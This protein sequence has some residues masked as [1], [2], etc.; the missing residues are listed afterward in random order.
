[1]LLLIN[2]CDCGWQKGLFKKVRKL[3]YRKRESYTFCRMLCAYLK[4]FKKPASVFRLQGEHASYAGEVVAICGRRR[5]PPQAQ[6]SALRGRWWRH[7]RATIGQDL[8]ALLAVVPQRY[9]LRLSPVCVHAPRVLMVL[10]P[11]DSRQLFKEFYLKK[12]TFQRRLCQKTCL[13]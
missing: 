13:N 1:M 11:R 3:T 5:A 9:E 6:P 8:Q 7:A 4:S 2:E 12:K 10:H